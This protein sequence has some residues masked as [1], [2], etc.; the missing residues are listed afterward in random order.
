MRVACASSGRK[1]PGRER[2]RIYELEY[3]V[4]CSDSR[5]ADLDVPAAAAE[6]LK[7]DVPFAR[8]ILHRRGVA[9]VVAFHA[10]PLRVQVQV[11]NSFAVQDDFEMRALEQHVV[12]VPFGGFVP[13][14][15]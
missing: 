14:K 8:T 1:I 6:L 7:T 9:A 3:L 2:H 13:G 4:E 12:L 10:L 11:L 5:I 15:Q